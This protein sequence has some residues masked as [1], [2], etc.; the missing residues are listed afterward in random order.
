M[1]CHS[2]PAHK[3]HTPN[4]AVDLRSAD[5]PARFEHSLGEIE[6]GGGAGHSPTRPQPRPSKASPNHCTKL[7]PTPAQ[8]EPIIDEAQEIYRENFFPEVKV[9][10]RTYPDF[11][12]H[13][14][15]NGCFRCHDGKHVTA[16]GKRSIKAS[17]CNSCHLILAQ[18]S[19]DALHQINAKGSRLH[20]YRRAVCGFFLHRLPHRRTSEIVCAFE[21]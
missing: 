16:D 7:I 21:D 18:G 1:D 8:A 13:K 20:A 12:G 10:W 5:W 19:G 14:N 9:D 2:R 15:W 3:V 11:V 6:S 4:D 17:D